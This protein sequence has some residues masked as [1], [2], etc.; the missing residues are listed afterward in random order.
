MGAP[1]VPVE[2]TD[3]QLEDCVATAVYWYNYYRGSKEE[4]LTTTLEGTYSGGYT[5]PEEVGGEDNIIEI[6]LK[7]RFPY[8][9]YVGEEDLISNLYM[10]WFFHRSRSGYQDFLG[11][12][13]IT[14]STEKDIGNILGT[15]IK[16]NFYGGKL[17]IHPD[18]GS[19]VTVGI[20]YK[21]AITVSEINTNPLIRD[22]TL[23]KAKQVLGTIRATFGGS[24]PGGGEMITLRGES[25]I[26]EGKEEQQEVLERMQKLSVPMFLEWG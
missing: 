15:N 18:P 11:D 5:I 4:I 20:R 16:W 9:Y 22:F 23:A 12:Y 21:G 8:T 7:P 3:E 1:T 6:I 10:Q 26:A 25:L 17:Y 2:L 13:Y 14:L 19:G 24:I